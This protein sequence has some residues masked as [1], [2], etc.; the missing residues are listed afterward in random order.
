MGK[1]KPASIDLSKLKL[2][3]V[4]DRPHLVEVS[5]FAKTP[6]RGA[7]MA[8]WLASLPG[9][10][11]VERLRGAV[12]AIIA[13]RRADRL[14]GAGF[15]AHVIKVGCG[16][17]LID[18]MERGVI[19]ALACNGAAAIHDV[20]VAMVGATSEDVAESI[21]DGSFGMVRETMQFFAEAT[22]RG[23]ADEAGLG[24]A[25]GV[26][27]LNGG[28]PHTG[29]S[30]F[31]AAARLNVPLTVHVAVG[32]DT[33]HMAAEASGADIGR[34]T[35]I[36]FRR[37]CELVGKLGAIAPGGRGGV[38]C[39][40]GSAVVMPEVFLKAVSVARNLG[41]DLDAMNTLNLDMI[42]HYRPAQN[43]LSRPVIDGESF[44][45]IGHHEILLP[46][47]RQAIVEQWDGE[48]EN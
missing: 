37:L 44:E 27:L 16:P 38:W 40:I 24:R 42:R 39:N 25:V 19:T 21:R 26:K 29:L 7:S 12:A 33:V 10:L 13:A 36:D 4:Y 22:W 6:R 28:F 35:L 41:A 3:S 46:L 34:A 30:V 9:F 11:G 8:D 20:E 43:V 2:R 17:I 23:A 15:G 31:A 45:I 1:Q 48:S 18:L 5:R 32:T 47:L 14:V